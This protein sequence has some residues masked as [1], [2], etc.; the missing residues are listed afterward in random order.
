VPS[1]Q[2]LEDNIIESMIQ[3]I[4]SSQLALFQQLQQDISAVDSR[5]FQNQ[6]N[7]SAVDSRI[8]QVNISLLQQVNDVQTQAQETVDN[9]ELLGELPTF[10]RPL[11]QL[12]FP[13]HPQ[14]S[15]MLGTPRTA[16]LF[17]CTVI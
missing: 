4:N 6:E 8:E 11:V 5:I 12:Y 16:L 17:V 10:L 9:L 1:D 3:E 14:V 7:I 2:Q 13:P 15:T